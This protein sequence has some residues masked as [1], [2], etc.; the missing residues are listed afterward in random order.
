MCF[1]ANCP[2]NQPKFL[3]MMTTTIM[4]TAIITTM[5]TITI[6]TMM[7]LTVTIMMMTMVTMTTTPSTMIMT[8]NDNINDIISSRGINSDSCGSRDHENLPKTLPL[9]ICTGTYIDDTG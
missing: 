3:S 7:T 9:F 4:T 2:S 6:T 8:T 5:I 1:L